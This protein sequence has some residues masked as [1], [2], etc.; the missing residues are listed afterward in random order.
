MSA[1]GSDFVS[2]VRDSKSACSECGRCIPKGTSALVSR[3]GGK[4]RK[5]VCSED[6]R[7]EFDA[8]FWAHA[9]RVNAKRRVSHAS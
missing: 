8:R 5:I 9:A 1:I 7:L 3:K 6:C 4:V 2:E